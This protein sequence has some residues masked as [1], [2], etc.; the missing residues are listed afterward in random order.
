MSPSCGWCRAQRYRPAGRGGP[1]VNPTTSSCP[2]WRA[3]RVQGIGSPVTDGHPKAGMSPASAVAGVPFSG[4]ARRV[5]CPYQS[6]RRRIHD[7]R[8]RHHKG[9]DSGPV[10]SGGR[11]A[12]SLRG[13]ALSGRERIDAAVRTECTRAHRRSRGRGLNWR[14]ARALYEAEFIQPVEQL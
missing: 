8:R 13:P 6:A 4:S 11:D 1:I 7:R 3:R 9:R 10:G 5:R 14:T 12:G 2:H